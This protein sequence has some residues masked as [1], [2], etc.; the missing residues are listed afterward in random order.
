MSRHGFHEKIG[1]EMPVFGVAQ[2]VGFDL[3]KQKIPYLSMR[4]D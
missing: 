2:M 3:G 1:G 4:V